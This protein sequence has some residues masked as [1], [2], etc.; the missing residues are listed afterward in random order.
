MCLLVTEKR[1]QVSFMCST[2]NDTASSGNNISN[3]ILNLVSKELV[4]VGAALPVVRKEDNV[5]NLVSIGL[6]SDH[7]CSACGEKSSQVANFVI[8][9]MDR[10]CDSS[11]LGEK[12][13]AKFSTLST[14]S[15]TVMVK[16]LPVVTEG[17]KL[18]KSSTVRP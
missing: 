11:A 10:D 15:W 13:A 1:S 17:V 4:S 16:A 12:K 18:L 2:R 9:E 3:Q 5:V 8:D 14:M 7:D 6:D